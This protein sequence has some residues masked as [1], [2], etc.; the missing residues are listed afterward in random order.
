MTLVNVNI[1]VIDVQV[2]EL[3]IVKHD[4]KKYLPKVVEGTNKD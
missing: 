1:E 3:D 4:I 2:A